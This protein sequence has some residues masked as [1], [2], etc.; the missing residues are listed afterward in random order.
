[1]TNYCGLL[2][3]ILGDG[4]CL[5]HLVVGEEL[6]IDYKHETTSVEKAEFAESGCS[7]GAIKVKQS[8]YWPGVAQR[9]PGSYGSQIS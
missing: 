9:V 2:V 8:H 4:E 1:M 6:H 5:K 3:N 7:I